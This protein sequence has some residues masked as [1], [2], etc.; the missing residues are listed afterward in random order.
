MALYTEGP[1]FTGRVKSQIVSIFQTFVKL[2]VQI[3]IVRFAHY[4]PF[5]TPNSPISATSLRASILPKI[6]PGKYNLLYCGE[7]RY[8]S[9]E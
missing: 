1:T 2:G 3:K 6:E 4:F 9:L 7:N 8:G 5:L